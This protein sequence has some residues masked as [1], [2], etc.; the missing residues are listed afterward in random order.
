MKNDPAHVMTDAE[1]AKIE[2]LIAKEYKKAHKEVSA[3]LDDYLARFANKDAIW[4]EWVKTGQ[5]TKAEYK[6]WA[7]GQVL[8]GK[9]WMEL[10]DNLAQDY[11]NAALIAQSIAKE[12]APG[13]Y[14]L[15]HNYGTYEIEKGALVDTSY[16]LYNKAAV[17]RM[18]AGKPKLYHTYGK[19]VAKQIKEGKQY[20]WDRRRIT[21]VLT[22]AILQGES[23]PNI[24]KRLEKVTVGDHKAAIRNARTM[25]TGVQN[26]GR[27]DAYERA[28]QMGI[29]VQKRWISTLDTRTRHWH[30]QLDGMIV[31]LDQPFTND[32]GEIMFP[33]DPEADGANV[34]NCRCTMIAAIKGFAQDLSD[35]NVRPNAKLGS[36]SY[37]EWLAEKKSTSNPI[38]LPE[39]KAAAIK[40]SWIA[41]YGGGGIIENPVHKFSAAD[42]QALIDAYDA[43]Q[44][45]ALQKKLDKLGQQE[46][47]GIWANTVTPKDFANMQ[48][49]IAKKEWYFDHM[50]GK[51]SG[52][53]LETYKQKKKMLN[54]FKKAGQEYDA[55]DVALHPEKKA[56]KSP[57]KPKAEAKVK[58]AAETKKTAETASESATGA[59]KKYSNIWQNKSV[60]PEDYPGMKKAVNDKK[61]ALNKQI[62]KAKAKGDAKALAKYQAQMDELLEFEK[63]GQKLLGAA[64]NVSKVKQTA[65]AAKT[66]EKASEAATKA[67]KQMTEVQ[68]KKKVTEA[69][70]QMDDLKNGN[71]YVNIWKDPVTPADYAEKKGSIE[72]KKKYFEDSLEQAKANG[73]AGKEQKFTKLLQDLE[74]FEKKGKLYEQAKAE[75][76]AA[77][78]IIK[79]KN[80]KLIAKKKKELEELKKKV[81][82]DPSGGTITLEKFEA[83][84]KYF[85]DLKKAYKSYGFTDDVKKIEA[86][87]KEL[88][89]KVK[90]QKD[91]DKLEGKDIGSNSSGVFSKDA[92]SAERKAKAKNFTDADDADRFWRDELDKQWDDLEEY[93]KY[94]VWKYTENSHPMNKPLA[95]YTESW[96]RRHFVGVGKVPWGREDAWRTLESATFKRKFGKDAYGHIDH[97]K[98]IQKLT[99]GIEKTR[100][101]EDAWFVRGSDFNGLAG[102]IEGSEFTFDEAKRI[103]E[104]G[105]TAALMRAFQGKRCTNHAFTS[106]GIARGTGFGGD[107]KYTIYAPKGTKSIYAE[108]ASY[109]GNTVR[110][111]ERIYKSGDSYRGVGSE[112]EMIFQRGTEFRIT[113]IEKR[114]GTIE[115]EME[116]VGQPNYFKTGL[117]ETIDGGKTKHKY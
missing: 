94:G 60:G 83:N 66:A 68:A 73:W 79:E 96:D 3:K 110:G 87:E 57:V 10:R 38:D 95:G 93:E 106:T 86:L 39:Q 103:L 50:I 61:W 20:A 15:N 23:I 8:A 55:L 16:T 77:D 97:K 70:A 80:A 100:L 9:R 82:E 63:E 33:G 108:P 25:M 22:Q 67:P 85:S 113:K 102:W 47:D 54:D 112:A 1:I 37:E 76:D 65:E 88:K 117:E 101:K 78:K 24:T 116:I 44:K 41:K 5:K 111:R 69:Q 72:A 2:K 75:F 13:V 4:Q 27:I 107:V 31:D 81:Y 45:E 99:T 26:A 59:S 28:A 53:S 114:Y 34:Y 29:P 56:L 89:K 32:I 105:D 115:V 51:S 62:E 40:G 7:K 6:A 30:R 43:A 74:D 104:S 18:Y 109:F 11:A 90:L 92:Y 46:F 35:P 21:S 98:A 52:K 58:Q 17:E 64:G 36:M 48:D 49:E 84:K 12:H 71:S 19:A 42:G 14:A 91:I